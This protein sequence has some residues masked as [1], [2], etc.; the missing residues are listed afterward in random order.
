MLAA[1]LKAVNDLRSARTRSLLWRSL[2]LTLALLV[3][4]FIAIQTLFGV[5]VALPGWIEG[6]IHV[7][8]G[9]GLLIVSVFLVAPITAAI[10]GL[11]LD[12]IAAHI[13]ETRYASDPPGRP[14]GVADGLWVS[15][16]FAGLVVVVNVGALFL[17]LVPGINVM[18]F[19]LANGYL[20]GRE[21]FELAAMRHMRPREARALRRDNRLR[22]FLSGLLIAGMVSV[23][24][25]NLL[26]PLFATAFMVHTLKDVQ[27]R[28]P[29]TGS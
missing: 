8:G 29:E 12:D 20:L 28:R 4:A 15:L 9:L 22:V 14:L 19:Y 17:L 6:L 25:V 5:L 1:A 3:V 7:L 13:E 21:Y 16:K 23:P 27:R 18:A 11:Y 26:T 10:A 2:G 24:V